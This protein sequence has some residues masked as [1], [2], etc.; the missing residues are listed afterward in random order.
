MCGYFCIGFIDS[1]MKAKAWQ[2]LKFFFCT[3]FQ[4]EWQNNS[5]KLAAQESMIL[6]Q[7]RNV[8]GYGDMPSNN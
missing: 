2:I 1:M 8:G 4:K 5:E 7:L 3:W 6:A